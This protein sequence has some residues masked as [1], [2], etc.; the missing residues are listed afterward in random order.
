MGSYGAGRFHRPLHEHGTPAYSK[1]HGSVEIDLAAP[2]ES[3]KW[4]IQKTHPKLAITVFE[5]NRPQQAA[6]ASL[7]D[8]VMQI[9][10]TR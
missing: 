1:R 8:L 4:L 7:G 6:L 5:V 3:Q 9:M 2:L 10:C